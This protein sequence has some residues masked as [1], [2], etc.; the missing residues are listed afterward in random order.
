MKKIFCVVLTSMLMV[1]MLV[2]AAQAANCGQWVEYEKIKTFCGGPKCGALWLRPS[3]HRQKSKFKRGCYDDSG[4]GWT[5][6][7]KDD[8]KIGCC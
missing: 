2:S 6:Y 7:K 1:T 5:E 3:E 8:Y 4:D